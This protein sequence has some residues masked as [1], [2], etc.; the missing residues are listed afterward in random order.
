MFKM[1]FERTLPAQYLPMI[2]GV[3]LAL[4]AGS[5]TPETPFANLGA[6]EAVIAGSRLTYN[7]AMMDQAP[8]LR[9]I[10][11]TGIG[12]NNVELAAATARGIAVCNTPDAPTIATAEHAIA[13]IFAVARQLKWIDKA[14]Q[15]GGKA[16]FFNQYNGLE[17]YGATLGLIG[18]GRIGSHVAKIALGIGMKVIAYDPFVKADQARQLGVTLVAD[19]E[20]VLSQANVVSLHLP[21]LTETVN[22]INRERLR[23][24]KPGAILINV[25][26]GGLVDE[27]ALSEALE[28]QHLAGVG[29]D[30]FHTE[31]PP[32]NHPLLGR[33]NVVTTPHVAGATTAG[34]DRLW[35]QALRQALQ[36]LQGERPPNLVNGEVW[37]G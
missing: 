36:V 34:K 23:R 24:M 29:L 31:P 37:R 13:L 10:A 21:L 30:V 4:A 2:E 35:R 5:D 19:L 25:A 17:L 26:R 12:Y 6:A 16:D 7:A 11:R 22:L 15:T 1:W 32:V 27:T 20:E 33:D 28:S 14:M 9:V 18:L 3:A 8:R